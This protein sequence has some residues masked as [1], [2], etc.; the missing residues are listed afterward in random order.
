MSFDGLKTITTKTSL[1]NMVPFR[2]TYITLKQLQESSPDN[3]SEWEP[4]VEGLG[5]DFLDG[6]VVP[7][8]EP[9]LEL[10]FNVVK[11]VNKNGWLARRFVATET[12]MS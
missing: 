10:K 2:G 3:W 9:Y 5:K 11:K 7:C 6:L 4:T 8:H 1:L 12:R